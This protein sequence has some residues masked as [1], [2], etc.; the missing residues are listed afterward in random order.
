MGAVGPVAF[1]DIERV[2]LGGVGAAP[3]VEPEIVVVPGGELGHAAHDGLEGGEVALAAV[4]LGEDVA[5]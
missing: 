3:I 5:V 1:E 4:F 2:G